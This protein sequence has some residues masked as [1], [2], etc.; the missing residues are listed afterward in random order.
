MKEIEDEKKRIK[1]KLEVEKEKKITF[2]DIELDSGR[3]D[4]GVRLKWYQK[5]ENAAI[6]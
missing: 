1:L 3:K 5:K 4:K 6:Y 2:L